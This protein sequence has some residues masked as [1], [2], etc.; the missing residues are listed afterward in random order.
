MQRVN[1]RVGPFHLIVADRA[2]C[3]EKYTGATEHRE[4]AEHTGCDDFAVVAF[5]V[6]S[7]QPP[8]LV[9]ALKCGCLERWGFIPTDTAF[10]AGEVCDGA[11]WISCYAGGRVRVRPEH[12]YWAQYDYNDPDNDLDGRCGVLVHAIPDQAL[13]LTIW[14][15]YRPLPRGETADLSICNHGGVWSVS[16]GAERPYEWNIVS[17]LAGRDLTP[18][19]SCSRGSDSDVE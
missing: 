5:R 7:G 17:G 6:E 18:A 15:R 2:R 12:G 3:V 8:L 10:C 9:V 14:N 16:L 1:E 13:A 11:A 4:L 19:L